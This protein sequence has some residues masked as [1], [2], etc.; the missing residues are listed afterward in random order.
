MKNIFATTF[1][2][3]AIFCASESHAFLGIGGEK[4]R[5]LKEADAVFNTAEEARLDGRLLDEMSGL[6][7]ARALYGKVYEKFPNFKTDH[8]VGRFDYCTLR[9]RAITSDVKKGEVSI[10]DADII[11]EGGG[12]GYVSNVGPGSVDAEIAS[13]LA[14]TPAR[15]QPAASAPAPAPAPASAAASAPKPAAAASA[16]A[17]PASA[18][19]KTDDGA[20]GASSSSGGAAANARPAARQNQDALKA[21]AAAAEGGTVVF[22]EAALVDGD[23]ARAKVIEEFIADGDAAE[24]VMTVEDYIER[25]GKSVNAKTRLLLVRALMEARNYN[26]A[27]VEIKKLISDSE[28]PSPAMRSLASAIAFQKG[29]LPEAMLHL[30]RLVAE[31]PDYADAYV[32]MAY[33]YYMMEPDA[34]L[35]VMSYREA[36]QSGAKRDI[37]FEKALKIT[38]EME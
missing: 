16:P 26:R 21:V 4:A 12:K 10:P 13:V 25:D 37:S 1:M 17:E 24:A 31:Y 9:V 8:V 32:N 34:Q 20:K 2:A 18:R 6:V 23:A 22:S 36:L 5:A 11:A 33:L 14:P 38:V 27:S 3:A 30:D 19:K 7:D 35:A 15:A 29:E 28:S